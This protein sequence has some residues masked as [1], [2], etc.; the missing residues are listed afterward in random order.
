V[1]FKWIIA[2]CKEFCHTYHFWRDRFEHWECGLSLYSILQEIYAN[3]ICLLKCLIHNKPFIFWMRQIRTLGMLRSRFDSIPLAINSCLI[4]AETSDAKR[5]KGLKSYLHNR[6]KEVPCCTLNIFLQTSNGLT[7]NF[8]V[9]FIFILH[10]RWNMRI[11][12]I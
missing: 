1:S 4:P 10:Y 6:F 9:F 5:K 2:V 7:A 11:R 8:V 3:I 12:R